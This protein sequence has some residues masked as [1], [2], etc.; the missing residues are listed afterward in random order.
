MGLDFWDVKL[1]ENLKEEDYNTCDC[2]SLITD[3]DLEDYTDDK[4]LK[5]F[6]KKKYDRILGEFCHENIGHFIDT[7]PVS[8]NSKIKLKMLIDDLDIFFRTNSDKTFCINYETYDR[9]YFEMFLKYLKLA[10]DNDFVIWVS[11]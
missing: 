4:N 2:W 7:D 8:I 3:A 9:A 6:I 11:H 5:D 1:K 10:Y